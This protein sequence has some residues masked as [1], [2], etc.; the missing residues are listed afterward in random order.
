MIKPSS[1]L[2]ARST[3]PRGLEPLEDRCLLSAG[4]HGAVLNTIAFNLA[5]AVVQGGLDTLAS[6]DGLAAPSATQSVYLGNFRGVETYTIDLSSTGTSSVLTVDQKGN[7]V[8]APTSSS[9]MFGAI[10]NTAVTDEITTIATALNLTAPAST[11]NVN[12]LT[13]ADKSAVYTIVLTSAT[14][15]GRHARLTCINVDSNGNPTGNEA[16]PL[17]TLSTAIQ[18]GLTGNTPVG[19]TVLTG[20]SLVSVQTHNGV[21]TYSVTYR[22]TGIRTMITVDNTGALANLPSTSKVQFSTIPTNAQT[23]LQTLAT[24]D[25]YTGTIAATQNISAYD[26]ANG[27]TIYSVRLPVTGT[28]SKSGATYT[29]MIAVASDQNGNPTVPPNDGRGGW[30]DGGWGGGW[31]G[32]GEFGGFGG[33][34]SW[35]GFS[36]FS[37]FS[38]YAQALG[39]RF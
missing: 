35:A 29:F 32:F 12:V 37:G 4:H 2:L 1:R 9:T 15:T 21:T 30:G 23:E 3:K 14:T 11:T 16:I 31:G 22:S 6:T 10:T 5:P 24:S 25:G 8:T 13:G 27:T 26:E 34:G 7:P 19:A 36:G 18:G 17:S 28:S 38:R 20:A 33:G 39:F